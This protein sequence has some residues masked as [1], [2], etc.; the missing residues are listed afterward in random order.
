MEYSLSEI[1][2]KFVIRHLPISA[3]RVKL[4]YE[5]DDGFGESIEKINFAVSEKA[6]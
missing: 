3:K 1:L 2:E 4:E 6:E 5:R